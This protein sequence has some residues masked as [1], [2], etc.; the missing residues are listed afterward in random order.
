MKAS[1]TKNRFKPGF[2]QPINGLKPVF[3]NRRPVC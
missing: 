3:N 1:K 2:Q